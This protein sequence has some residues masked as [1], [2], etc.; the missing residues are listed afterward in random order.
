MDGRRECGK[1]GAWVTIANYARH[2][3]GE[4]VRAVAGR[5]RGR[6][7]ECERCGRELSEANMA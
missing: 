4:K 6:V 3:R 7:R 1:C 5:G 2:R